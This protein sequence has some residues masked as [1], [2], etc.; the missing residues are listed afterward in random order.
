MVVT[1]LL[2]P[3]GKV[4]DIL[5]AQTTFLNAKG[6]AGS[7]DRARKQME[8]NAVRAIR[9]WAFDVDVAKGIAPRPEQLTGTIL[10]DYQMFGSGNAAL[11]NP[12]AWRHET[13]T[14]MKPIPWI[15][16]SRL[17][18]AVRASDLDEA[19]PM[20]PNASPLRLRDGALL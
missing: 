7:C 14:A 8:D 5:A 17:A 10:V 1:V 4:D 15:P 6:D 16:D 20:L 9:S 3:D 11:R 13:R 19:M 18:Q 2:S 12:G